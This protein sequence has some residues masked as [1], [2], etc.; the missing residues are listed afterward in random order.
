[1]DEEHVAIREHSGPRVAVDH[2]A[3]VRPVDRLHERVV[4]RRVV[5]REAA[6]HDQV[7]LVERGSRRVVEADAT[8]L[9][10]LVELV[11]GLAVGAIG[12]RARGA[13]RRR[14]LDE[15]HA[16]VA[17]VGADAGGG[18]VV[19]EHRDERDVLAEQREADGH[20]ERGAADELAGAVRVA[21]LVDEGVADDGDPP[22]PMGS[23]RSSGQPSSRGGIS[24]EPRS[25]SRVGTIVRAA[26]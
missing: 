19:A 17:E 26:E 14:A 6:D 16:V 4:L 21:Q 15:P 9:R 23:R 18:L 1:M 24:P 8:A 7:G 2:Q 20:V 22:R 3:L 5:E 13:V 11:A 25:I 12:D 10:R